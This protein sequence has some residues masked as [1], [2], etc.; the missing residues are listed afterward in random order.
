MHHLTIYNMKTLE[1]SS[2][3]SIQGGGGCDSIN[4]CGVLGGTLGCLGSLV[5]CVVLGLA[6]STGGCG[7]VSVGVCVGVHI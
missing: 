7:G 6:A 2:L 1:M 5:G 4:L 3:E